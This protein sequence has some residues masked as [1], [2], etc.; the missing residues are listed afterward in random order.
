MESEILAHAEQSE[1]VVAR[2]VR[3]LGV[4]YCMWEAMICVGAPLHSLRAAASGGRRAATQTL[5]VVSG[6]QHLYTNHLAEA[7]QCLLS[8]HAW[9]HPAMAA[10]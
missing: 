10:R 7:S 1:R 2:K 5:T 6:L 8:L 3:L 9:R 4:G